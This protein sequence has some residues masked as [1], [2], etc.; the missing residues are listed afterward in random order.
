MIS[1]KGKLLWKLHLFTP[2]TVKKMFVVSVLTVTPVVSVLTVTPIVSVL[3]VTSVVD[4][5]SE[6]LSLECPVQHH[7]VG[8]ST[9][10]TKWGAPQG[11]IRR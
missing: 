6:A 11:T 8:Q 1:L 3:T 7:T 10:G 5:R 9:A 2:I 4:Y